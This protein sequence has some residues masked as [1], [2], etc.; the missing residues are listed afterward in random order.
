MNYDAWAEELGDDPDRDFI[1]NGI[2][3]GFDIIDPDANP[4]PVDTANH[5]SVR[6]SSDCHSQVHKQILKE[7]E[8]GNYVITPV[9]PIIISPL[10]AIPKEDG[11]VRLIHDCSLPSGGAVNDYVSDQYKV[12]FESVDEAAGM[13]SYGCYMAKLDLKSA[14]RSVMISMYSQKVTGLR[15]YIDGQET[16]MYDCKL[17]FGSRLAPLIFHRL[18]QAVKRIMT[19][20]GYGRMVAYMDDFL[21][22]SDSF[23]D[24]CTMLSVLL[25]LVRKLGFAVNYNKVVDPTQCLTF[26]GVEVNSVTGTLSLPL[27]KL[28]DLRCTLNDFVG[29]NRVSKRQ[30]QSILGSLNWA[31]S[32]VQGGRVF[33]R[34]LIDL[35]NTLKKPGDRVKLS[36]EAKADIAWWR[37]FIEVFNGKAVF[38]DPSPITSVYS[39]ACT[40]AAGAVFGTDWYYCN[41]DIDWPEMS[42]LHI[43]YKEILAII[44]CAYRWGPFWTGKH[45]RIGSDNVT[46]VAAIN[47]G[48]C[49]DTV[50]REGLYILFWLSAIFNFKISA[51][52]VPGA[53]N[54]CADMASRL[55]EGENLY[56]L[57]NMLCITDCNLYD[58]MSTSCCNLF[59][60]LTERCHPP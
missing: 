16:F 20:K 25:T 48:R 19:K 6:A 52:H 41:F 23:D 9:K 57:L 11:S 12:T 33:T 45:I 3:N 4:V 13:I 32:V 5:K 37:N 58:H 18:S 39:D 35:C 26:L 10:G 56:G 55:H 8:N 60:G 27:E 24:C 22:M 43:N 59:Q 38:I 29:R 47:K 31:G 15:W 30:L 42:H 2:R 21:V 50:V 51:V 17:P 44:L 1:L 34:R 36:M 49:H 14:Y 40:A 54:M 7:I 28:S 46:A 53:R